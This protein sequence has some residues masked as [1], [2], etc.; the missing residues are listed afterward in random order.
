M[1]APLLAAIP[2]IAAAVSPSAI[3][4]ATAG[5]GALG[6]I[7]GFFGAQSAHHAAVQSANLNYAA[8]DQKAQLENSQLSSQ[9]SEGALTDAVAEAQAQGRIAASA[10]SLG[11]GVYSS[12]AL[13]SE[14]A[15]GYNRTIGINDA[16]YS[17]QRAGIQTDLEG[18]SLRRSSAIAAAPRAN[19]GTL[20][21]GLA[22]NVLQGASVFA[23]AGGKFGV[24]PAGGK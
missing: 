4:A 17:N 12:H 6:S 10:S 15:A 20:A 3:G 23:A 2:A 18:A 5:V 1:C 19:L 8:E 7:A 16:N 11:L 22:G 24:A 21:L 9:Q 14:A 13:F